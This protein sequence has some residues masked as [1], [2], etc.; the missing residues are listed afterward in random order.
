MSV[1]R[2]VAVV[3]R[4]LLAPSLTA[5]GTSVLRLHVLP[6]DLDINLHMNNGRYLTIMDLGRFD[7]LVRAR[8]HRPM[9]RLR[10]KA[11]VGSA[12]IRFRRSLRPFQGYTL[13]T[14][15]LSWD[16]KW[17]VFEQ[18]FESRGEL[19]AVGLVRALFRGR[20]GNVP[21]AEVLSIGGIA[22]DAPPLPDYVS[23]WFQ[24]DDESL[25]AALR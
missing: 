3:A 15:L 18:R 4:G 17:F 16:D 1:V 7:L 6:S 24:A 20:A 22:A 5:V 9:I 14:R 2:M 8:L 19:Y 25:T 21:P 12:M 13:H 11:L 23:A 10:W